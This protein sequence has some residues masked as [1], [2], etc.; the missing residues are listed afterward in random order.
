MKYDTFT[1]PNGIKIIHKYSSSSVA[2]CGL[3]VNTGSR[4]ERPQEHGM[5]HFIEHVIFKGTKRRNA[6]HVLSRL[7]DVGGELNAYTTKEETCIYASFLKNDYKRAVELIRDIVF[8][9]TF[10][11]KEL[12]KEKEVIIDEINAYRDNPAESISDDFEELIFP[13]NPIGRNILGNP[14]TI[15]HFSKRDI[16]VFLKSNYH[17]DQMVFCSVGNIPFK[18]INYLFQRYFSDI[19]SSYRE[20]P[21]IKFESYQPRKLTVQKNTFQT[22]CIIGNIAYDVKDQRRMGLYLLNNILGGQGL[23]SRLNLALREKNGYAYN[24]ESTYSPYLDTG[25]LSIYFGTD[26]ENIKK[27]TK[28]AYREFDK[29]KN[30]KLG[31]LQLSRAK[32]QMTGQLART[33]ENNENVMLNMAKSYLVYNKVDSADEINRK[34]EA[35]TASQLLKIANDILDI[36]RLSTLIYQ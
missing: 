16:Y 29:L 11:D 21:R 2:H 1:L 36:N 22:H 32:R 4:D 35:V 34:I 25:V 18:K 30:K 10:P 12:T 26:R 5:A 14:E 31:I 23:N 27:S 13:D 8:N 9:S 24:I 3:M 6:Y 28:L 7:E 20:K 33:E 19:P 17:T 15:R